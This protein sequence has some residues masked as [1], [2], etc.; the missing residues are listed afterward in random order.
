MKQKPVNQT[1]LEM[2]QTIELVQKSFKAIMNT[3]HLFKKLEETLNMLHRNIKELKNL[4][5]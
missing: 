4:N 2:T 3:L 5:F 1:N